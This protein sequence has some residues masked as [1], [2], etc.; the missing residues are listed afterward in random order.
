MD[1]NQI[2]KGRGLPPAAPQ[3]SVWRYSP[4]DEG[5]VLMPAEPC[6]Y[7]GIYGDGK[8]VAGYED[9]KTAERF[10]PTYQ[11]QS[12]WGDV[13]KWTIVPYETE[14]IIEREW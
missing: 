8:F 6:T 14:R 9:R 7:Y 5:W 10:L 12:Y 2:S 1:T 13:Q 11:E 4:D 3:G